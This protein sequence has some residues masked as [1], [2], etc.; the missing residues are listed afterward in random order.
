MLHPN[1]DQQQPQ[2][3]G[4]LNLGRVQVQIGG[5]PAGG[6]MNVRSVSVSENNGVKQIDADEGDRKVHI[7][8]NADGSIKLEI[9]EKVNGKDVTKKFS[10]KS[11]DELKKKSPKAYEAYKSYAEDGN[12]AGGG[13]AAI[14]SGRHAGS[15]RNA[16]APHRARTDRQIAGPSHRR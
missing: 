7:A 5:M 15:R 11:A 3:G 16:G 1:E 9:T 10:A 6:G 8:K 14:E 2:P 4:A 13:G 12:A